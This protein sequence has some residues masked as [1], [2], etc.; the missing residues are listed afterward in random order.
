MRKIP[1]AE[2]AAY[3]VE[4]AE[5]LQE[6]RWTGDEPIGISLCGCNA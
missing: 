6:S 5:R 3:L 4:R 2:Y 1:K